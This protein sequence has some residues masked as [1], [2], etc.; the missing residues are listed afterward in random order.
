M[1]L[2]TSQI[3]RMCTYHIYDTH[4]RL[5]ILCTNKKHSLA[6]SYVWAIKC[7]LLA[8]LR[9]MTLRYQE[10][11]VHVCYFR[12]GKRAAHNRAQIMYYLAEN[13]ELRRDEFAAQL[14]GLTGCSEGE[15][16]REVDLSIDRLFHWAAYCD[17]YGGDVQ[18][19]YGDTLGTRG[20]QDG[21]VDVCNIL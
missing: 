7:V 2:K 19:G 15:G 13:L 10:C 17:K 6:C 8:L 20:A 1:P 5:V 18:V 4:R 14:Q 3:S 12:W 9:K 21:G 16:L 11:M